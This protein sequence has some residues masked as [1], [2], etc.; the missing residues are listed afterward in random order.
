MPFEIETTKV[1]NFCRF[2]I[3]QPINIILA[4]FENI[5]TIVC[6]TKFTVFVDHM[7]VVVILFKV[8]LKNLTIRL[9]ISRPPEI[10]RLSLE[11]V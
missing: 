9:K 4:G 7:A 8:E 6:F 3:R 5:K 2:S 11:P 1:L 10:L